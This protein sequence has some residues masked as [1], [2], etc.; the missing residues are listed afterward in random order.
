MEQGCET[1]KVKVILKQETDSMIKPVK[2]FCDAR[3]IRLKKLV[4][5]ISEFKDAR[6]CSSALRGYCSYR[7]TIISSIVSV[8]GTRNGS[9][10]ACK[11]A[12]HDLNSISGANLHE[13]KLRI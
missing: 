11:C 9:K 7:V 12:V 5:V 4:A 13:S 3:E 10:Q 8:T 1:N 2:Y 6:Y